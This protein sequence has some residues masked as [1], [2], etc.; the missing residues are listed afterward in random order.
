MCLTLVPEVTFSNLGLGAGYPDTLRIFRESIQVN[1]EKL[2]LKYPRSFSPILSHSFFRRKRLKLLNFVRLIKA[3]EL[4]FQEL[5]SRY[6]EY[7]VNP[8]DF[9]HCHRQTHSSTN[10]ITDGLCRVWQ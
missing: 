6:H 5:V 2:P 1:D 9:P 8:R 4:V 10:F 3:S 7:E